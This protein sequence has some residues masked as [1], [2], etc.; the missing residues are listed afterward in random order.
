MAQTPN[1]N[2]TFDR[3]L[4]FFK[5]LFSFKPLAETKTVEDEFDIRVV[6]SEKDP[7]TAYVVLD[8]K[9]KE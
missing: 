2:S 7:N 4:R 8:P 5:R 9:N 1:T 6:K 3:V